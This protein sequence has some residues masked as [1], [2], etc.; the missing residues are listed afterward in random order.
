MELK[1]IRSEE[2]NRWGGHDYT[3]EGDE[4]FFWW[5][6]N[7]SAS[8][9][10]GIEGNECGSTDGRGDRLVL[11]PSRPLPAKDQ[12]RKSRTATAAVPPANVRAPMRLTR[13]E[14]EH[15]PQSA[16]DRLHDDGVRVEIIGPPV[17]EGQAELEDGRAATASPSAAADRA[18]SPPTPAPA[19]VPAGSGPTPDPAAPAGDPEP[20]PSI[21]PPTD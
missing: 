2:P 1:I 4:G 6:N 7:T 3:L 5:L 16:L 11:Q 20:E 21:N 12:P 8:A 9:R 18:S 13:Q 19:P 15:L 10:S 17:A 14:L